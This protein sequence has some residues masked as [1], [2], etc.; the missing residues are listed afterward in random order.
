MKIK[1][2]KAFFFALVSIAIFLFLSHVYT[3]K[4]VYTV[5]SWAYSSTLAGFYHEPKNSLDVFF[6][7]TS[8]FSSGFLPA[9][10]WDE[11]GIK[12]YNFSL[13][14][15]PSITGYYWLK[16]ALN[17]HSPSVVVLYAR[18]LV[19][20]PDMDV[21]DSNTESRL[22]QALDPMRLSKTKIES[23][24][25]ALSQS[26]NQSFMDYLFP[27]FRFHSRESLDEVDYSFSY[28][29][30]RHP[31]M[32][33]RLYLRHQSRRL[34]EDF[35]DEDRD[36]GFSVSDEYYTKIIDLCKENGIAVLMIETPTTDY[37]WTMSMHSIYKE[38][39]DRFGVPFFDLNLAEDRGNFELD[40]AIDF[41]DH[42]HMNILGATKASRYI[43]RYLSEAMGVP[44]RRDENLDPHWETITDF[45]REHY[46]RF[47]EYVHLLESAPLGRYL[48]SLKDFGDSYVFINAIGD[49]TMHLS[50]YDRLSLEKLGL[51]T[52]F[53]GE[54][55]GGTYFAVLSDGLVIAE[56]YSTSAIEFNEHL[57][58]LDVSVRSAVHHF[59]VG[60]DTYTSD[61]MIND[62]QR[63]YNETGFNVV[64]YDKI[65]EQYVSKLFPTDAE[66]YLHILRPY[67]IWL[68]E[69]NRMERSD[70]SYSRRE[71]LE[72]MI[73]NMDL[74]SYLSD[75]EN[76]GEDLIII[77]SV[78]D[79]GSC[80]MPYISEQLS[81]LGISTDFSDR[82]RQ[83]FIS[84]YEM[85]SGYSYEAISP[86][87]LLFHSDSDLPIIIEVSSAGFEV[88]NEASIKI[89]GEEYAINSRG[90][91]VVIYDKVLGI[92]CDSFSVDT[93]DDMSF[94]INR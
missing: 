5:T 69:H 38:Y 39:A 88:G 2:I 63:S 12:S 84:V 54:L 43:A 65:S 62:R 77:T 11:A 70:S 51:E 79:E 92:V 10:M 48:S 6:L 19:Q 68:V 56:E 67:E 90:L 52:E 60:A 36:V 71:P 72:K 47:S 59:G 75:L 15:M 34:R 89:D 13:P 26:E 91:N 80:L 81:A 28:K 35:F 57:Q 32:G 64:V 4:R 21:D 66:N 45:Y 85:S 22:R 31:A 1:W 41:A 93:Y 61:I 25:D 87:Q 29:M 9:V 49:F 82:Y 23:I 30:S 50:E 16:E 78:K 8:N 3:E 20:F 46:L 7:G 58:P 53:E 40:F 27:L 94:S 44:D 74:R 86:D 42:D 14:A 18:W 73:Q 55:D 83:S 24:I 17:Y 76:V 37:E 33:S